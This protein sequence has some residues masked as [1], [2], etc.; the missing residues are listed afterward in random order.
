MKTTF[1]LS[2]LF[3]FLTSCS[4]TTHEP[5]LPEAADLVGEEVG[6]GQ[7]RISPPPL[8]IKPDKPPYKTTVRSLGGTGYV[9]TGDGTGP[10]DV[11]IVYND[12]PSFGKVT[13]TVQVGFWTK[14]G[15][16]VSNS[17]FGWLGDKENIAADLERE[18]IN[19]AFNKDIAELEAA[20]AQDITPTPN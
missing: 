10:E 4:V 19:A 12:A 7:G 1:I 6:Q 11:A 3:I 2:V 15:E 9:Y 5:V 16:K 8:P 14:L 13:D 18:K 20:G 17:L